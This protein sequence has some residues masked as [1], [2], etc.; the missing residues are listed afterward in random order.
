M[1]RVHRFAVRY[2][3][4]GMLLAAFMPALTRAQ[5][6]EGP[7]R[8]VA[9][10]PDTVATM[11]TLGVGLLAVIAIIFGCA[12]IVRRM[13]GMTGGNTRAIKVVSVMPMLSLIHI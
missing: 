5:E 3:V 7:A 8:E 4:P 2:G 13:S 1:V 6:Q 11:L 12:W 10:A 9:S